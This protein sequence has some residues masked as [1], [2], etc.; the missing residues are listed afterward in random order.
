MD[1]HSALRQSEITRK[2]VADATALRRECALEHTLFYIF[3][4]TFSCLI[5][6][7]L[8]RPLYNKDTY[9]GYHFAVL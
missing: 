6:P 4:I 9:K 7:Y 8:F 3:G 5:L 1:A 2:M